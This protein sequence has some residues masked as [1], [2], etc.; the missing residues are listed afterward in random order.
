MSMRRPEKIKSSKV[1]VDDCEFEVS[2]KD[3]KVFDT[4]RAKDEKIKAIKTFVLNECEKSWRN[5]PKTIA[6]MKR[7]YLRELLNSL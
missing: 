7:L 6:T 1:K 5:L 3:K 2:F 4:P